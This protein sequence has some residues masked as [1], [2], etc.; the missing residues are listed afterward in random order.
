MNQTIS[1][2]Q[3]PQLVRQLLMNRRFTDAA[4]LIKAFME[5]GAVNFAVINECVTSALS[6]GEEGVVQTLLHALQSS[7][8]REATT[9]KITANAR[10]ATHEWAKALEAIDRIEALERRTEET[11]AMRA[12]VLEVLMRPE[13]ALAVLEGQKAN[14]P[15]VQ[16]RFHCIRA[17]ALRQLKKRDEAIAELESATALTGSNIDSVTAWKILG[18]LY[19]QAG[20]YDDA[21][22]AW[23]K[24]NAIASS[25]Y[26]TG[27]DNNAFAMRVRAIASVFTPDWVSSWTDAG[28][29]EKSPVFLVGFPRSGTTLLE[30][31]L[32]A[33]SGIQALDEK[34]A[35]DR[36]LTAL[37]ARTDVSSFIAGSATKPTPE[38]VFEYVL[39]EL[40]TLPESEFDAL[41]SVY[42]EAV[43]GYREWQPGKVMVDKL[44]LNIASVGVLARIFP[45]A[46]FIV[47][48]RHPCDCILSNY[49]QDFELN[50]G[51]QFMTSLKS[52]A[53]LYSDVMGLLWQFEELLPLDG[54]IHYVRYEDV[55]DDLEG[56]SKLLLNFLEL[57]WDPAVARFYEHARSRGTLGTP[58]YQGVTQQIYRG[59]LSR[60]HHY[61]SH[62]TEVLPLVEPACERWGYECEPTI[63]DG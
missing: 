53:R 41:R 50:A 15:A 10:L 59:A 63:R 33:H 24:G 57:E 56:E 37:S 3:L 51:M 29:E 38:K 62:F 25:L 43:D 39:G 9:W 45:S 30:Q 4:H 36:L 44:P 49:M 21:F 34:P 26:Q 48:L 12:R 17:N 1:F 22:Q 16:L 7:R 42:Y 35:V 2:Q 19:D 8:P 23:Q 27:L 5:R 28:K 58:S 52:A 31:V 54:R 40:A 20:R 60:W 47:A 32:D 6:G 61:R 14:Q 11:L 18:R 13:E 46:R 55:V